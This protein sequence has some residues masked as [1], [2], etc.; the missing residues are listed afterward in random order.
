MTVVG[1][2]SA[3]GMRERA[4]A[5]VEQLARSG[6]VLFEGE[7]VSAEK[8]R[9]TLVEI[10]QH[11]G[12]LRMEAGD[13]KGAAEAWKPLLKAA[14]DDADAHRRAGVL[15]L[16]QNLAREAAPHLA[17]A[18]Q[19][20][21]DD[22]DLL[23]NVALS[24]LATGQLDAAIGHLEAS[25]DENPDD[26]AAHFHLANALHSKGRSGEAIQR[27]DAAL[28]LRPGWAFP[29]NNLAWILATHPADSLRDGA[30]AVQLAQEV[31]RQDKSSNPQT[32]STLA[33]AYAET[34][35]FDKAV[36]TIDR[37]K[38]LLDGENGAVEPLAASLGAMRQQYASGQPLRSAGRRAPQK[39]G[40]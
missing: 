2:F 29:A 20:N 10:H 39:D 22:A 23:F 24:E 21:P 40:R 14:P 27:Y 6:P 8:G 9:E 12:E 35:Q 16:T 30:R 28:Q 25:L 38:G 17:I 37:A 13:A 33:A 18:L 36:A 34:G 15:L 32:L 4:A 3:V 31:C 1:T 7:Y 11:L 5:Y 19:A 26:A